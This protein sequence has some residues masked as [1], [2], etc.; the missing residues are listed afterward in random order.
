MDNHPKSE[1]KVIVVR[2]LVTF[3]GVGLGGSFQGPSYFLCELFPLPEQKGSRRT[4]QG[5]DE[6][7]TFLRGHW[8]WELV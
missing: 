7:V 4:I 2:G 8:S 1:T 6:S 3:L 5:A